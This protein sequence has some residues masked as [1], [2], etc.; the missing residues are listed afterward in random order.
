VTVGR[1]T[2][3]VCVETVEDAVAAERGGADRL[4]LCAALDL[5]GLTPSVGAF[6]EVRDAV[7]L[8]VVVMIRPRPGDFVYSESEL[9][10]MARDIAAFLPYSPHGFVFGPLNPDG[11]VNGDAAWRL[12]ELCGDREAVFHR[13]FDRTPKPT[14]AVDELIR[15]R[16][17]RLLT[18]GKADAAVQ[19]VKGIA[20]VVQHA[21]GRV[22]VLPC[23][24][25]RAENAAA[26][27]EFTGC[28]QL[29]GSFAAPQQRSDERGY[30]GYVPASRTS[31]DAVADCRRA[32]DHWL[33]SRPNASG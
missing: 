31:E 19:G 17:T 14:E 21:A 3:E 1:I 24:R 5:G 27:L 16:F 7:K 26:V 6:L 22:E 2:L 15:L 11:R 28:R 4:E 8:P 30:R 20:E 23:G 33:A 9:A 13:A 29:H 18:S 25:I 12:R 10:V 32:A